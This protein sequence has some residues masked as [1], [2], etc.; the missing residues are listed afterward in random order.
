MLI[1]SLAAIGIKPQGKVIK[2]IM[3][4]NIIAVALMIGLPFS[5]SLFPPVCEKQGKVLEKEF[6]SHD[7]IYFNKGL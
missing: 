7:K 4:I 6:H 5:V 2:N 3:D 1:L